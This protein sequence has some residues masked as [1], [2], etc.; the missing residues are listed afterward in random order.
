MCWG[1]EVHHL[2]VS[3]LV[4]CVGVFSGTCCGCG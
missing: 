4:M 3:E 1:V 2:D